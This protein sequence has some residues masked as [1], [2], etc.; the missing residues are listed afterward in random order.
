MPDERALDFLALQGFNF[1]RV[2]MD[3]RFWVTQFEYFHPDEDVFR[4]T[5]R[6]LE[7]CRS[8]HLHLSL[9]LHRAPGYCINRNDLERHNLW[10]DEIAQDAFVH[11]WEVL[12]K[13]YRGVPSSQLS[14]DLINEPPEIG[15]Y[16]FT[17]ETHEAVIRRTVQAIRSLDPQR[18]IVIDGLGGG[19][20]AMPEL[21]DLSV[22]HSGRG[23]QPMPVTHYGAFWWKESA[24]LPHPIYPGT[25]W[26]GKLWNRETLRDFYQ[27]WREVEAAGARV[28]IGECGCFNRTPGDVALRWFGD[29]FGLF[30]EFGWGYALWNFEGPFGVVSHGRP[31][32]R[33]I[34]ISGYE[35][36]Q[37]LLEILLT[38]RVLDPGIA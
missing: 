18:E 6:Y 37:P 27:P 35:V 9:N 24:G 14:F 16:G 26:R 36:D 7:A 25:P 4:F 17:R 22:I 1:V 31:G 5:D 2:P 33:Y 28:H 21:A 3:Y 23:Y 38:S 12:T 32:A 10:K 34:P 11:Q 30:H 19:N 15:E 13:R 29:L 20:W 8:R